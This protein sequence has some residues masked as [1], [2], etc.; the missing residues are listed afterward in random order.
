MRFAYTGSNFLEIEECTQFEYKLLLMNYT[1]KVKTYKYSAAYQKGKWDGNLRFIQGKYIPFGSWSYLNRVLNNA[2]IQSNLLDVVEKNIN[3]ISEEEFID[4]VDELMKDSKY[5]PRDY[6]IKAAWKALKYKRC[7]AQ[8]ATSAGK[9]LIVYLIFS[10]LLDKRLAKKV[11]MIVPTV[12]LVTQAE[13]DFS[14]F[15][16]KRFEFCKLFEGQK[17]IS[18]IAEITVGTYQTCVNKDVNFLNKFDCVIVDECHKVVC[19]S[20]T[21]IVEQC[22]CPYKIGMSGTVDLNYNFSGALQ[23]C[24]VLGP[25]II[26]V[27]AKELQDAGYISDCIIYQHILNYHKRND[28]NLNDM[29][30]LRKLLKS[31]GIS[32]SQK[33]TMLNRLL[34]AEKNF[35]MNDEKRLNYIV[36]QISKSNGNGLILVQHL[37]YLNI[38]SERLKGVFHNR[39]I[40]IISGS[41]DN[42]KRDAIKEIVEKSDNAIIVATYGTM[43][44]GVSI[45]N[46]NYLLLAE[47]YKSPTIVLQSIG[48]LLRKN[49]NKEYAEIYDICDNLYSGSICAKHAT[50][51]RRLYNEQNFRNQKINIDF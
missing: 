32:E 46:L 19:K 13:K 42:V 20:E 31:D 11:L 29:K 39:P 30:N 4:Y 16:P 21:K 35:I 48:R 45:T 7:T 15:L 3:N 40:F 12:Q 49:P 9:T 17:D 14:T 1:K 34:D 28:D 18:D 23:T 36:E 27:K 25:L 41:I 24:C 10:Y 8:L 37:K 5:K 38:I 26:D 33:N 2:K 22:S 44:T 43:S 6:Q 50:D 47:S 51:R